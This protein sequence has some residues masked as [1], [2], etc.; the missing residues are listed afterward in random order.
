MT[1]FSSVQSYIDQ[2]EFWAN[3]YTENC[4]TSANNY[5]MHQDDLLV[6]SVI[7]AQSQSGGRGRGNKRWYSP[8]G[9][10]WASF[11]LDYVSPDRRGELRKTVVR[12]IVSVL[13]D[14]GIEAEF[15]WP[16][17]I[18]YKGDKLGGVLIDA[19]RSFTIVGL[20]LNVNNS[21]QELPPEV[22]RNAVSVRSI[23]GESLNVSS[24]LLGFLRHFAVTY[25]SRFVA[26]KD[27][28]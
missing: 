27:E 9:G 12:C 14:L 7:V 5:L 4:V 3:F 11:A 15:G 22:A 18:V 24:L 6:G 1:D 19:S 26:G 10:L 25:H 17:D 20:G 28:S 16:N 21:L 2:S 8:S 23:L 13:Q